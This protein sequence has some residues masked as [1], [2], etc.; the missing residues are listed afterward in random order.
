MDF[1][2]FLKWGIYRKREIDRGRDSLTERER[3]RERVREKEGER[4][5]AEVIKEGEKITQRKLSK[6]R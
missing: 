2:V 4:E 5:R 6:I 1:K 3:E